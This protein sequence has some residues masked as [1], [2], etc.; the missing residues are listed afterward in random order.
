MV[1][2]GIT[3]Y[4]SSSSDSSAVHP[5]ARIAIP[6]GLPATRPIAILTPIVIPSAARNLLSARTQHNLSTAAPLV[7]SG[8]AAKE[9]RG[10]AIDH[11]ALVDFPTKRDNI[12]AQ[13]GACVTEVSPAW[14]PGPRQGRRAAEAIHRKAGKERN[15]RPSRTA[16]AGNAYGFPLRAMRHSVD[17][18]L[19]SNRQMPEVRLRTPLLPPVHVF[20]HVKP[21]GMHPTYPR[22]NHAQGRAQS[23]HLLFHARPRRKRNLD[24]KFR[25]AHGPPHGLRKSLQ[26]VDPRLFLDRPRHAL[27]LPQHR[28]LTHRHQIDLP[29]RNV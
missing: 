26:K 14:I 1:A 17:L 28:F 23:M 4:N 12:A 24:A 25:K 8:E 2:P 21:L 27:A 20:R 15:L 29:Q 22:T 9:H 13:G 6:S 3:N 7:S 16:D 10:T 19:R 11:T 18:N 5:H